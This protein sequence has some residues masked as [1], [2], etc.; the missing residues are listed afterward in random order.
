MGFGCRFIAVLTVHVRI[1]RFP[2]GSFA[3]GCQGTLVPVSHD[4]YYH[5]PRNG[6]YPYFTYGVEPYRQEEAFL[7]GSHRQKAAYAFGVLFSSPGTTVYKDVHAS[8]L[9]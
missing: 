3:F 8:R 9:F 1:N 7:L 2:T 5:G 6:V 4:L